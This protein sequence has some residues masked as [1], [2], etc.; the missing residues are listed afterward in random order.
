MTGAP[1]QLVACLPAFLSFN[2]TVRE[3]RCLFRFRMSCKS[4]LPDR[5]GALAPWRKASAWWFLALLCLGLHGV[6]RAQDDYRIT[7]FE[8]EGVR[9][10]SEEELREALATKG[11]S[12][13]SRL[14]PGGEE[15]LFNSYEFQLDLLRI[16]KFYRLHGFYRAQVVDHQLAANDRNREI[17]IRVRIAEN[18]P[19]HLTRVT[20]VPKDS[21]NLTHLW[22]SLPQELGLK[23]GDHL[24][25][26]RVRLARQALFNRFADQGYPFAAI[27]PELVLSAD[28]RTAELLFHIDPG[29]W[30][31]FGAVQIEG[32]HFYP[33]R[34]VRKELTFKE[35]ERFNQRKLMES[36]QRIYLL[37]LFQS[38][39][40]RALPA[41]DSQEVL[42]VGIR[43]KEA[44]RR[45]LKLGAG[46]GTEDKLR[47]AVNWRRRN[48][49]GD[50]RRLQAEV[51]H[52]DLE[53]L[54]VQLTLFQPHMPDAPTS[55]QLS[56]YFWRQRERSQGRTVFSLRLLGSE[57]LVQ[58]RLGAFSNGYLRYRAERAEIESALG[59]T[60]RSGR[61]ALT[62][63]LSRNN[64]EPLFSPKR[65]SFRS[66]EIRWGNLFFDRKPYWRATL[67]LRRYL[68][69]AAGTVLALHGVIGSLHLPATMKDADVPDELYYAGGSSSV[70][71][72]RRLELGPRTANG[73][74]A[75]GRSLVEG[76]AEL[77]LQVW[78]DWGLVWFLDAGNVKRASA[79]FPLNELHYASGWGV[80]YNTPIGPG[81]LD[82]AWKLNKQRFDEKRFEF[83]LSVGQA[84]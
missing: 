44:P 75:G 7:A 45:T 72:W 77:R 52:S 19:L 51:K 5:G 22:P 42:P 27:E 63:G 31:R 36:Q 23:P 6:A 57:F 49:L 15:P 24:N 32:L 69:L 29:R 2:H 12:W 55:L 13:L 28:E 43:V 54:R 68:P 35:G 3:R 81:R 40:I 78:K 16:P 47:A 1:T 20:L 53:P 38:V 39:Q 10:V 8:L 70:R 11:P 9:Q 62:L 26:A 18:E 64:S 84:F 60:S 30:Q 71:G 76:S 74:V 80:R 83:H 37:E 25:E 67:D 65:G 21:S 4:R 33:S 56:P 48:F 41:A 59:I 58:R 34:V 79:A 14:L 73:I 17:R 61:S 50:A 46:W 66:L 82:F